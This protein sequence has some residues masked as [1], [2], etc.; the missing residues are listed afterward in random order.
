MHFCLLLTFIPIYKCLTVHILAHGPTNVIEFQPECSVPQFDPTPNNVSPHLV[1]KLK[2]NG[3]ANTKSVSYTSKTAIHK[4]NVRRSL[5]P[6][7]APRSASQTRQT[8][9]NF[10]VNPLRRSPNG[11]GGSSNFNHSLSP[12]STYSHNSSSSPNSS[13]SFLDISRKAE[14]QEKSKIAVATNNQNISFR[15]ERGAHAR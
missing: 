15:I 6:T 11:N 14:E 2:A 13:L 3:N 5:A 4:P 12:P 8:S 10:T 9:P 1:P 7:S